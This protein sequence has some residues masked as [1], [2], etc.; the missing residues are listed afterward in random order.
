MADYY[1]DVVRLLRQAGYESS[2]KGVATTKFGGIQQAAFGL[3][4]IES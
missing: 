1:R 3:L 4:S 2:D